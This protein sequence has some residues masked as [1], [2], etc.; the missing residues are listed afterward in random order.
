MKTAQAHQRWSLQGW[1]RSQGLV[2]HLDRHHIITYLTNSGGKGSFDRFLAWLR[3]HQIDLWQRFQYEPALG[4]LRSVFEEEASRWIPGTRP[5]QAQAGSRGLLHYDEWTN[6]FSGA[7]PV[8][9]TIAGSMVD[10]GHERLYLVEESDSLLWID[11]STSTEVMLRHGFEHELTD[12]LTYRFGGE[13]IYVMR[14]DPLVDGLLQTRTCT[15]LDVV[16]ILVRQDW[17]PR[18]QSSLGATGQ[19]PSVRPSGLTNW[20]WVSKVELSPLNHSLLERLRLRFPT[21]ADKRGLALQGG[22]RLQASTYLVGGEPDLFCE[23]SQQIELKVDDKRIPV[24]PK[25]SRLALLDLVLAPGLHRIETPTEQLSFKTVGYVHETAVSGGISIPIW[26]HPNAFTFGSPMR[27]CTTDL[28]LA[29]ASLDG[30]EVAHPLLI[31][32]APLSEILLITDDGKVFEARQDTPLWLR[33]LSLEPPAVDAIT[34]IHSTS[35]RVACLAIRNRRTNRTQG[36]AVPPTTQQVSGG[37]E[38]EL[39]PDV[40]PYLVTNLDSW[41]WVGKPHRQIRRIL[42]RAIQTRPARRARSTFSKQIAAPARDDVLDKPLLNNPFDE[43]LT[44]ISERE[45]GRVP[46]EAFATTWGWSCERHGLRAM[47]F[48]WRQALRIL[49][50]LG[51]V[52]RDYNTRQVGVAPATLASLPASCG[53][54]IL[55]GSRPLR[56]IERLGDPDDRDPLV[57]EATSSWTVH[58][59]TPLQPNGCPAG[60]QAVYIEWDPARRESVRLGL[61][62]LGVKLTGAVADTLLAMQPSIKQVDLLGDRLSMSPS[63]EMWARESAASGSSAWVPVDSDGVAGL[64]R[65][66]LRHKSVFAW[67]ASVDSELVQ[68]EFAIGEWLRCSAEGKNRMIL[69]DKGAFRLLAV[70]ADVPLPKLLARSL[71]LRSGLPPRRAASRTRGSDFLVYENVDSYSAHQVSRILMQTLV[72]TDIVKILKV[73][74]ES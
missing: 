63:R 70:P 65:Y 51:H 14:N 52:E 69:S 45:E 71:T 28:S 40:I 12:S 29:G 19:D 16:E 11:S 68:V 9:K 7:V 34:A 18:V 66:R 30:A 6:T 67:R 42:A 33:T 56:L 20:V 61:Q 58:V 59:R 41:S 17:L 22:L 43:V 27:D 23:Y 25:L 50:D 36:I 46:V 49:E 26:Q 31:R 10:L 4:I 8:D 24:T 54:H 48:R 15:Q 47:A 73:R 3:T 32:R 35:S 39:R 38:A 74:A 44:W 72:P 53:L 5:T 37:T 2:R 57:A 21:E 1:A 13:E 64:Y 55:T 60:P 62:N